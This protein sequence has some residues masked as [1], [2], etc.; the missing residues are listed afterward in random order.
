M[1]MALMSPAAIPDSERTDCVESFR[2]SHQSSGSCSAHPERTAIMPASVFGKN[3]E[4][5]HL[6]VPA[7]TKLAL[8]D[9]LPMSYPN[10]NMILF[11][12]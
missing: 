11:I 5:T 10:K 1:P 6:P 2:F 4:A 7:S 3:A 12:N 8:T 9:E